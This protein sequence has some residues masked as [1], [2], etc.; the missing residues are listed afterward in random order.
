LWTAL[1]RVL[2][3][4]LLARLIFLFGKPVGGFNPRQYVQEVASNT[5]FCKHDDTVSFVID[6]PQDCIA[7]I[8]AY[9]EREQSAGRLRYGMHVSQTALMTC[10]V[11]HATGGLHVHFVDGGDG[12]Y[13]SAARTLKA[14]LVPVTPA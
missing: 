8:Q 7:A 11:T 9:L 14:Q 13:T 3:L 12:G 5:D 2:A 6:C 10:L 1:L 4:T